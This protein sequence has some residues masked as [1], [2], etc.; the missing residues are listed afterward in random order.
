MTTFLKDI[1]AREDSA[2][3]YEHRKRVV[4]IHELGK[5]KDSIIF[6][7]NPK[8]V[9]VDIH[10]QEKAVHFE[11]LFFIGKDWLRENELA[12]SIEPKTDINGFKL[13]YLPM[14]FSCL[15]SPHTMEFVPD[16][17][18]VKFDSPRIKVDR[19]EDALTPLLFVHFIHLVKAIIRKGLK[20]SYYPVTSKLESR[21]K[22]KILISETI[23]QQLKTKLVSST[24]CQYEAYGTDIIENRIIKK[25]LLFIQSQLHHY[26]SIRKQL[27]D[28]VNYGLS[29]FHSISDKVEVSEIRNIKTNAF[30]KEYK[31]SLKVAQIILKR[32]GTFSK[33]KDASHKV[34]IPP[35]WIDMSLLFELFVLSKLK[36]RFGSKIKY[37]FKANDKTTPDFLLIDG[38][39]KVIIDAKYKLWFHKGDP[40]KEDV[41]QLAAYARNKKIL[42]KGL[43]VPEDEMHT[44]QIPCLFI[45]PSLKKQ[46]RLPENILSVSR[47]LK[48]Y[49]TFYKL[50]IGID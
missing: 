12:I 13:A 34:V 44:T 21:V 29:A 17:Y 4:P 47:P 15:S 46:S 45:Y 41:R 32:Y 8:K 10:K 27:M 2:V 19:E 35:Y 48:R 39:Q 43:L 31:Q 7:N 25:T 14:L 6:K 38:A 1:G 16:I 18:E 36:E 9:C 50:D 42:N 11:S 22:G 40:K 24:Q 3:F 26:P 5:V 37:Q 33:V 30:F 23:K 49:T 20:K 28:S